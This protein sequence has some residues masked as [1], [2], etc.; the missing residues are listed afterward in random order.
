MDT[1]LLAL[2]P[3]KP[4]ELV[5]LFCHLSTAISFSQSANISAILTAPLFLF[6]NLVP[7]TSLQDTHSLSHIHT[8]AHWFSQ[9]T[10]SRL[11]YLH[12]LIR[13]DWSILTADRTS[14]ICLGKTGSQHVHWQTL[15]ILRGENN[16]FSWTWTLRSCSARVGWLGSWISSGRCHLLL[17][18]WVMLM[19]M[20]C[21][22]GNF[23]PWLI[24]DLQQH[25]NLLLS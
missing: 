22:S 4:L 6:P 20:L 19:L 12:V 14:E 17:L 8:Q 18:I 25:I 16:E 7:L 5:S 23:L 9:N 1:N 24:K 13:S 2:G 3:I 10:I 15:I 21:G 11:L